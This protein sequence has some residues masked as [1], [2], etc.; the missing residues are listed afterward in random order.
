[1]YNKHERFFSFVPSSAEKVVSLIP[2]RHSILPQYHIRK[3]WPKWDQMPVSNS[4]WNVFSVKIS[5][6]VLGLPVE[7]PT[8]WKQCCYLIF[9]LGFPECKFNFDPLSGA[10]HWI[11]RAAKWKK[12]NKMLIGA[13]KIKNAGIREAVMKWKPDTQRLK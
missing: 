6:T 11:V 8:R 13:E 12:K 10:K 9:L 1:M 5:K 4:V 3:H 7:W 2:T